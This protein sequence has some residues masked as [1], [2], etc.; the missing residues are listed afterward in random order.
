MN[1]NLDLKQ[2]ERNSFKLATYADGI[3]DISLGLVMVLLSL[4]PLTRE[5]FGVGIN[6][7]FFFAVL[8]LIIWLQVKFKSRLG[9]DRIGLVNF[10]E[11]AQK[12]MKVAV[13]ITSILVFLTAGTWY[14]SSQGY[15]LP[16][17]SIMGSYGFDIMIAL[18][19]LG[20]F[21]AMAYALELTRFY[22]YGLLLS[23]A[24]LDLVPASLQDVAVQ[25]PMGIAGLI[26]VAI[27]VALLVRFLDK[28]PAAEQMEED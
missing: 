19:V 4:Y 23:V 22:F 7:L 24:F 10:G 6:I 18:I 12:R 1:T 15:M 25:I 28:Y 27:G 5:V 14:L 11:K 13:L 17:G 20:I 26:I 9:P 2:T 16:K 8:G 21:S 3:N